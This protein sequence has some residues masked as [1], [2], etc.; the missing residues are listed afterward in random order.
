MKILLL[1]TGV[2]MLMALPS[3]ASQITAYACDTCDAQGAQ[4]LAKSY[5]PPAQCHFTNPPGTVATPDDMDCFAEPRNLIVVNPIT[6]QAYKYRVQIECFGTWCSNDV[7]LTTLTLT[8]DEQEVM[9][10][11]YDI[12]S[13]MRNA[14]GQMNE[15]IAMSI[16][17]EFS[18]MSSASDTQC[19]ANPMD[20]FTNLN[21]KRDIEAAIAEK[22]KQQVNNRPWS[23]YITTTYLG[24]T[25]FRIGR[26]TAD[27]SV[28][29]RHI[30]QPAYERYFFG[31]TPEEKNKN[32]LNFRVNY[33]GRV[34]DQLGL[35]SWGIELSVQRSTSWVDGHR[36]SNLTP[37]GGTVNLTES[38]ADMPCFAEY[39]EQSSDTE[40]IGP[41]VQEGGGDDGGGHGSNPGG[42]SSSMEL[43]PARTTA[44]VCSTTSDG[45]QS[46]T[47]TI[48]HSLQPCQ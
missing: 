42:G 17:G 6:Q 8:N 35:S 24:P 32:N 19:S 46:C 27:V 29:Q 31:D 26:R 2:L 14:I 38:L 20:Y 23:E 30:S 37:S 15:M 48:F 44:T 40:I 43:C 10:T 18:S 13:S 41:P 39:I 33:I 21:V 9:A 45:V 3:H 4:V 11:Y 7:S 28:N 36:L 34:S 22:I 25:G 12:D 47:V 5:A 16:R 1:L